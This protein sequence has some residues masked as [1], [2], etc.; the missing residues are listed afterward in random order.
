MKKTGEDKIEE[1]PCEEYLPCVLTSEE[2]LDRSKKLA[3]ANEDAED[4]IKRKKDVTADFSAQQKKIEAKIGV[5]S[6]VVSSGKEYRNDVKCV[7]V[8]NYTTGVKG[9]KR[10]DTQE[11]VKEGAITQQERQQAAL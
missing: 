9:L 5:L 4:L 7:W 8:F 11:I 10:L 1:K 3:K 6:R 2:F